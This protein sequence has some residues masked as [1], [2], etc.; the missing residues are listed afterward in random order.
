MR[1][2]DAATRPGVVRMSSMQQ[3]TIQQTAYVAAAAHGMPAI[4]QPA[5]YGQSQQGFPGYQVNSGYQGFQ[6]AGHVHQGYHFGGQWAAVAAPGPYQATAWSQSA[7]PSALQHM[8]YT[9]GSY[10]PGCGCTSGGCTA[11]CGSEGCCDSSCCYGGWDS[12]RGRRQM[13]KDG[14]Q[15]CD[16]CDYGSGYRN[17]MVSLFAP[18]LPRSCCGNDRWMCR[19]W[20]GQQYNYHARNQRLADHLFGWLVP[21][22]CCGQGCP[23]V[24]KYC[25]TYADNPGYADPRDGGQ[26][27][28]VQGYGVPMTVPLA[29]TVRQAYNYSWGTPSSR[30]TPLGSYSGS[31]AAPQQLYHQSW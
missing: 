23:P 22:G 11:G 9:T 18:A 7:G 20:R 30:I 27:Y 15:S 8:A 25:V 21:S 4:W 10:S 6:P 13:R 31:A 2:S 1:I 12:R 28:G 14:W 17:R 3:P 26:P 16:A 5:V 24:G 19:W 29:P